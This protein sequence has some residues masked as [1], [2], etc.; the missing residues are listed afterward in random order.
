MPTFLF[1]N[2]QHNILE[3]TITLRECGD[4]SCLLDRIEVPESLR[5]TG[6]MGKIISILVNECDQQGVE[7]TAM[8]SPDS[9]DDEIAE[10]MVRVFTR[11]GFL[12]LEMD[13]EIYR[14]DVTYTPKNLEI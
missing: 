4:S 13:G 7:L 12:P 8:I 9:D 6:L 14:K 1:A 2:G 5:R 3:G 10:G 11:H